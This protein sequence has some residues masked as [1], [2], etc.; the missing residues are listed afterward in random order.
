MSMSDTPTEVVEPPHG[1]LYSTLV[2]VVSGGIGE[3]IDRLMKVSSELDGVDVESS[4][5][6]VGPVTA[7]PT[8]MA[9]IGWTSELP[10][11]IRGVGESAYRMAYPMFRVTGVAVDTAAYVAETTGLAS[12]VAG[13]TEPFR[14]AVVEERQ[15][16]ADIGTAEY[17]RGR[18]LATLAFEQSVDGIVGL[19][20]ESEELGE[21]V[22]EQTL[23]VTGSAVQE[24]R[25]T[26]AAADSLTEGVFRRLMR[27]PDRS[28]PP[29]PPSPAPDRG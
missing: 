2:R 17:L 9:L 15:R 27:R 10:S 3:G 16:L 24:I 25:E 1:D 26:S 28:V 22:R 14:T 19:L 7:D 21:L 6:L 11:M 12:F 20:S 13:V 18:K 23:G 29:S 4:S 5:G 8:V